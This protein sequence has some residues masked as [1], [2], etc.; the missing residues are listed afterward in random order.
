MFFSLFYLST[1]GLLEIE[2]CYLLWFLSV[3]LSQYNNPC[4]GY[5]GLTWLT[6]VFCFLFLIFF[7]NLSSALDWLGIKLHNLF[8]F[9]FYE[10]ISFSWHDHKF[11]GL[12]RVMIL[13]GWLELFFLFILYEVYPGLMTRSWVWQV[14]PC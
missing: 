3:W 11:C 4:Y 9:D 1:F 7:S 6:E 12:T 14:N 2:F 13:A 8:W 5:G 10:V